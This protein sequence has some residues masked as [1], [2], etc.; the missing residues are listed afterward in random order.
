[1][2]ELEISVAPM[3]RLCKKAGAKRVS[4]EAAKELARVLDEIGVKIAKEAWDYATYAGRKT[5]KAED[6][7][8]AVR[9]V[10][11]K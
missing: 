4:G 5:I 1:M 7:E 10:M 8:I 2:N 11:V 3:I 6:I 9:K